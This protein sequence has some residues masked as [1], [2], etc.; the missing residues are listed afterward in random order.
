MLKYFLTADGFLYY[1]AN[2]IKGWICEFTF[3]LK[4]IGVDTYHV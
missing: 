3:Q 1:N 4:K 2:M